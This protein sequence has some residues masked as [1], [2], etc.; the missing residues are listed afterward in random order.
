MVSRA[1]YLVDRRDLKRNMMQ[2]ALPGDFSALANQTK[3]VMVFVETHEHHPTF[4]HTVGI[5]PRL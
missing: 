3:T 4:D 1:K 5:R 2:L